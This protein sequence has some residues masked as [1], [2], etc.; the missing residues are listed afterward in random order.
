MA[1]LDNLPKEL[2]LIIDLYS[3]PIECFYC[4]KISFEIKSF[5]FNPTYKRCYSCLDKCDCGRH[6]TS[7]FSFYTDEEENTRYDPN[8][9]FSGTRCYYCD[10]IICIF[11]INEI[12][13]KRFG[14]YKIS[15]CENCLRKCKK[16]HE[17]INEYNTYMNSNHR[18]HCYCCNDTI[19][20]PQSHC[21]KCDICFDCT[22][23]DLEE[24][25]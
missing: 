20:H 11:C 1:L 16:C 2:S 19:D 12:K 6:C 4:E 25:H 21:R 9:Y 3:H 5:A 10:K 23:P 7:L 14:N 24:T 8:K 13:I 18:E 17:I 15:S 22:V